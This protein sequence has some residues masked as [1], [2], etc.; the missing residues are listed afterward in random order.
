M[1]QG[2]LGRARLLLFRAAGVSRAFPLLARPTGPRASAPRN[3][4]TPERGS[5]RVKLSGPKLREGRSAPVMPGV[6]RMLDGVVN[7]RLEAMSRPQPQGR[8]PC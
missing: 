2:A 8:R 6:L 5:A 7:V 4:A 1:W 3:A